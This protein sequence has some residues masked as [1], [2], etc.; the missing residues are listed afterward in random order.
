VFL[1]PVALIP[2]PVFSSW[3]RGLIF[4]ITLY[5]L[6]AVAVLLGMYSLAVLGRRN[7]TWALAS[8]VGSAAALIVPA[9][10]AIALLA[11]VGVGSVWTIRIVQSLVAERRLPVVSQAWRPDLRGDWHRH[12]GYRRVGIAYRTWLWGPAGCRRAFRRSTISG[13]SRWPSPP[14]V[15]AH[16]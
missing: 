14:S 6:A 7:A 16:S 5:G 9:H 3:A 12:R 1:A 4:G 13:A 11:L 15:R 10:L 2:G 8:F